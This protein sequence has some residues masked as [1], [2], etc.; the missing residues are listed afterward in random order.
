MEFR[1]AV[2]ESISAKKR[3]TEKIGFRTPLEKILMSSE[4]FNEA[5]TLAIKD[6]Q[7][8]SQIDLR[9]FPMNFSDKHRL[10][11]LDIWLR[12]YL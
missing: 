4:L 9:D 8:E 7:F 6:P 12:N 11:V 10:V 5:L 2:P 3:V 1:R